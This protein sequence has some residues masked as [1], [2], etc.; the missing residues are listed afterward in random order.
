MSLHMKVLDG[1]VRG[2]LSI[3]IFP[4]LVL[5]KDHVAHLVTLAGE[6]WRKPKNFSMSGKHIYIIVFDGIDYCG[7]EEVGSGGSI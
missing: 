6:D 4:N 5:M 2:D 7:S 1:L 3:F